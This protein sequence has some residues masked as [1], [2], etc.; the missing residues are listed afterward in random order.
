MIHEHSRTLLEVHSKYIPLLFSLYLPQ[1]HFE[2][3]LVYPALTV[4][5]NVFISHGFLFLKIRGTFTPKPLSV[6]EMKPGAFVRLV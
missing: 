6:I 4:V 5:L 3:C 1:P 2:S